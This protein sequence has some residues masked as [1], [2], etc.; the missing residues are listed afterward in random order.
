MSLTIRQHGRISVVEL[1][2]RVVIGD[3]ETEMRQAI[4]DL[5]DA[6]KLAIVVTMEKLVYMDSTGL[7]QLMAAHLHV[8]KKGGVLK[9]VRPNPKKLDSFTI[10][11]FNLVFEVFEDE[12]DA[13]TSFS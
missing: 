6:G 3:G 12:R 5:A 4:Q 11:R 8:E 9:V 13:L 7:G 10:A 1:P 2:P